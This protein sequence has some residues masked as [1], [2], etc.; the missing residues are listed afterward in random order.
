MSEST[1][2]SGRDTWL[3]A[4]ATELLRQN[5]HGAFPMDDLEFVN[6]VR[7][8]IR[9]FAK[10]LLRDMYEQIGE[11]VEQES[12]IKVL[13][14]FSRFAERNGCT[15]TSWLWLVV[16]S[17]KN[18]VKKQEEREPSVSKRR[19]ATDDEAFSAEIEQALQAQ[20]EIDFT[21]DAYATRLRDELLASIGPRVADVMRLS[22]EG[23]TNQEISEQMKM[24]PGTVS[25][26]LCR[27]RKQCRIAL[28][29]VPGSSERSSQK[30][31][32]AAH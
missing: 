10:S 28:A 26:I 4:R 15:F 16:R 19:L 22:L 2:K 14:Y 8:K 17:A 29:R 32:Y 18:T 25:A 20:V 7:D 23:R 9:I 27:V 5:Q 31:K 1:P 12:W 30:A 11:Q 6:L 21:E 24:K 13:R 3:N